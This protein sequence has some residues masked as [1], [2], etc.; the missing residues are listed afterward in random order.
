MLD[1]LAA[2]VL[3]ETLRQR[4]RPS[5]PGGAHTGSLTNAL[6]ERLFSRLLT[7]WAEKKCLRVL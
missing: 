4:Q 3:I 1:L 6:S 7:A 5:P 2:L